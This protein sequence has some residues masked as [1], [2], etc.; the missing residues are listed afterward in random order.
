MNNFK[1]YLSL[2]FVILSLFL[3]MVIPLSMSCGAKAPFRIKNSTNLILHVSIMTILKPISFKTHDLG[4][5]N[6]NEILRTDI[7]G[8]DY[9]EYLVMANE[10]NGDVVGRGVYGKGFSKKELENMNWE[11]I[12][13]NNQQEK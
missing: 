11:I 4:T 12:I 3:T 9:D 5:L 13:S 7:I 10:V 8:A 2:R 6:P 1:K